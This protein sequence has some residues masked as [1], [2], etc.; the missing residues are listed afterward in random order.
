MSETFYVEQREQLK[1][2]PDFQKLAFGEIFTDYMLS[3]SYKQGQSLKLFHMGQ[4]LYRQVHKGFIMVK[5][6]LKA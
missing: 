1:E 6:Y 3:M 4:L 2:K 5:Q